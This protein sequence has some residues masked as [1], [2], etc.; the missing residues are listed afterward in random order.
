LVDRGAKDLIPE[1]ADETFPAAV[2]RNLSECVPGRIA[3]RDGDQT[4]ARPWG[5]RREA[6]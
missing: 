5:V 1:I 4:Q 2:A 6:R 3:R